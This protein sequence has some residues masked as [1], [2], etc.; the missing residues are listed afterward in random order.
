MLSSRW[1]DTC[2]QKSCKQCSA[3]CRST[4]WSSLVCKPNFYSGSMLCFIFFK[5]KFKTWKSCC[6]QG[7]SIQLANHSAP[8]P[9]HKSQLHTVTFICAS[10][11]GLSTEASWAVLALCSH[12]QAQKILTPQLISLEHGVSPGTAETSLMQ[13]RSKNIN[14]KKAL[15]L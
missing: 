4:Q 13:Q 11:P 10:E 9:K 5:I 3:Q 12:C 1:E 8:K 7:K 14:K 2:F 15:P 6:T